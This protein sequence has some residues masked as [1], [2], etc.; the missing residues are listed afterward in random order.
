[1]FGKEQVPIVTSSC[2][3]GITK[4]MGRMK[5]PGLAVSPFNF[6]I[7]EIVYFYFNS[8]IV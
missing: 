7:S 1:M 6:N 3:D 5:K 2:D 4:A 8:L